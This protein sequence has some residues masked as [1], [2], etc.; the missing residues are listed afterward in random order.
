MAPKSILALDPEDA[1]ETCLDNP[2]SEEESDT[3]LTFWKILRA[4]RRGATRIFIPPGDSLLG[5]VPIDAIELVDA[6]LIMPEL[7]E[8]RL[9]RYPCRA[10]L[11]FC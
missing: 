6:D 7:D 10:L 11:S 4:I 1:P 2:V 5:L 3:P 8:E 9:R